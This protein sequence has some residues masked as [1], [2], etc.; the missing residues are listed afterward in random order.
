MTTST[1]TTRYA[2]REPVEVLGVDHADER[3]RELLVREGRPSSPP[4]RLFGFFCTS[5]A[6]AC[7][8]ASVTIAKAIPPTRRLTAP[9]TSGSDDPDESVTSERLP[10]RPAVERDRHHVDADREVERVPEREQPGVPEE[11]VVADRDAG[12]DQAECRAPS[13]SRGCRA[14]TRRAR[15]CPTR[16]SARAREAPSTASGTTIPT[17]RLTEPPATSRRSRSGGRAASS[18]SSS[19]HGEVADARRRVV[20]RVLLQSARPRPRRPRSP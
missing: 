7:A 15:A 1:T 18:A 9:T 16:A 8:N 2:E 11:Q 6:P 19:D 4:V 5:T 14:A 3:A 10:E 17:T 12:E 20:V 13:A